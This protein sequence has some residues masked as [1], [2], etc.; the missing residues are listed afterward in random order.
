MYSD[1][2]A[3]CSTHVKA[4]QSKCRSQ[5]TESKQTLITTE[6]LKISNGTITF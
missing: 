6:N 5:I 3:V 2:T 4:M 1:K